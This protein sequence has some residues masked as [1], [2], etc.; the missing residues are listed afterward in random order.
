MRE[1]NVGKMR[2]GKCIAAILFAA[3]LLC[4][5]ACSS[6]SVAGPIN[7]GGSGASDKTQEEVTDQNTEVADQDT[8]NTDTVDPEPIQDITESQPEEMEESSNANVIFTNSGQPYLDHCWINKERVWNS[9]FDDSY[10]KFLVNS[11]YEKIRL[12]DEAEKIYPELARELMVANDL[13]ATEQENL[14]ISDCNTADSMTDEEIDN[15]LM[16]QKSVLGKENE[17]F[18][19]RV[20]GDVL[21]FMST[22]YAVESIEIAQRTYRAFNYE[23]K[24]GNKIELSDVVKDMNKFYELLTEKAVDVIAIPEFGMHKEDIDIASLQISI[25]EALDTEQ[26]CWTLDP[27][28]ITLY[29]NTGVIAYPAREVNILFA[30]DTTGEIFND[31]YAEPDTWVVYVESYQ[32]YYYVSPDGASHMVEAGWYDTE[33]ADGYWGS[34]I[35][36]NYD[37]LSSG[38][39]KGE[40]SDEVFA[41]VRKGDKYWFYNFYDEYVYPAFDIYTIDSRGIEILQEVGLGQAAFSENSQELGYYPLPVVTDA[42][43]I[44]LSVR[45]DLL[46]TCRSNCHFMMDD[47]G[48]LS[49]YEDVLEFRKEYQYTVTT[50]YDMKNVPEV[51]DEGLLTGVMT[52]VDKGEALTMIRTDGKEY[53]DVVKQNGETVRILLFE[54]ANGQRC[55]S[56]AEGDKPTYEMF[57]DMI[58]SQ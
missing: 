40:A 17:M 1:K 27:N 25:K 14:Y 24:T 38:F 45:T 39:T 7:A 3:S 51:S 31:K 44:T 52:D 13:I 19:R 18:I 5:T 15:A 4:M 37:G 43:N 12:S 30:E 41:L 21:S 23:V 22:T 8:E 16:Y 11:R 42:T 48:V 57:N 2:T 34:S 55:V 58:F 33:D 36:L 10:N 20:D 53:V 35:Y 46:S 54:D 6:G 28:G 56:T 47:A 9:K 26:G 50:N 29:F 49:Q 32:P